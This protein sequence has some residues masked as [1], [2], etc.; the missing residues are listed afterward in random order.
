MHHNALQDPG[1]AH[2]IFMPPIM[3]LEADSAMSCITMRMVC[4]LPLE[5]LASILSFLPLTDLVLHASHDA[6]PIRHCASMKQVVDTQR[7]QRCAFREHKTRGGL[8]DAHACTAQFELDEVRPCKP[9]TAMEV[10]Q[11]NTFQLVQSR[12]IAGQVLARHIMLFV[13]A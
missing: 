9:Q 4:D 10:M 2:S 6:E 12:Q 1:Y 8:G 13:R 5:C 3:S 7:L 11:P